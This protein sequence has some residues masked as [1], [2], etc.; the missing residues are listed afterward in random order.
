[1]DTQP[2]L[3]DVIAL[4]NAIPEKHVVRGQVGTIVENLKNGV[5]E[6]EF[7]DKQGKAIVTLAL[8]KDDFLVLHHEMEEVA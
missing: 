2:K 4:L 5:Y 8:R 6:V 1:M 7:A 3:L